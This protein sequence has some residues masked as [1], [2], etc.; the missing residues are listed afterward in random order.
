MTD[1]GAD[2]EFA[3]ALCSATIVSP[4]ARFSASPGRLRSRADCLPN[5]RVGTALGS[6]SA[7]D[8]GS[9]VAAGA[10]VDATLVGAAGAGATVV[11]ITVTDAVDAGATDVV[12]AT[13]DAV[14]GARACVSDE[15][16]G[17]DVDV[18]PSAVADGTPLV[19]SVVDS[20]ATVSA[21]A[22]ARVT[23]VDDADCSLLLLSLSSVSAAA[24]VAVCAQFRAIIY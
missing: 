8:F 18:S 2:D 24:K 11:G 14:E 16:S 17:D 4:A 22:G 23:L 1:N 9:A 19:D 5:E 15:A 10:D 13:Y 3:A 7:V 12:A 6:L 20:D 21:G